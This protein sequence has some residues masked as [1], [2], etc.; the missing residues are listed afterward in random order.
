MANFKCDNCEETLV[1]VGSSNPSLVLCA[2]CNG[3]A[4]WNCVDAGTYS[5]DCNF[6]GPQPWSETLQSITEEDIS[7]AIDVLTEIDKVFTDIKC[8]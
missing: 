1:D 6:C 8:W 5:C 2:E 4:A 7:K 3:E